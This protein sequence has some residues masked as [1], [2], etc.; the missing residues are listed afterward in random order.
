MLNIL[1]RY[2]LIKSFFFLCPNWF[3]HKTHGQLCPTNDLSH[4]NNS[5][6]FLPF[7][8]NVV[9]SLKGLSVVVY[10]LWFDTPQILIGLFYYW[11]KLWWLHPITLATSNLSYV[12]KNS[13]FMSIALTMCVF[14]YYPII[15]L[16]SYL[17]EILQFCEAI[18]YQ[19]PPMHH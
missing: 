13:C 11:L 1:V 17:L 12:Q 9:V 19:H 8:G 6:Y 4:Q 16:Y 5:S 2:F 18:V 10:L 15:M 3:N 14:Y 7:N